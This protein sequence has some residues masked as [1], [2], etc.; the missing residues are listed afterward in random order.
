MRRRVSPAEAGR[1]LDVWLAARHPDVTR[2]QVRRWID[3]GRVRVNAAPAKAGLNLRPGDE[4]EWAPPEAAGPDEAGPPP[5]AIPLHVLHQDDDLV[6]V[7]KPPG[8]V[9]HPGAGVT[10]GT[11]VGAL[12]GRGLSLARLG[13]PHRP[14][15]VHRLDK[16]TSGLLVVARTDRAY[17]ALVR[18]IAAR[19]VRRTY[20]ALVWGLVEEEGGEIAAAIGRSRADR[21]RMTVVRRG[22]REAL[23]R[24][25]VRGRHRFLTDLDLELETGRTHQIRVHWRHRG[26]PVF[27]DPEY[28]GRPRNAGLAALDRELARRWLGLIDR[29][30]LHAARLEFDHPVTGERLVFAAPLPGDLARL[31]REVTG[32][33][34]NGAGPTPGMESV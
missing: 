21:R 28:G 29:Q 14:G 8:M 31:Y 30:A 11:L 7:D 26:H 10:R 23:T 5:E 34:E 22:G 13:G 3:A 19:Q 33:E 6:V 4:V 16:N 18:A 15:I 25:R 12:R 9:V 32:A 2:S 20:R 24:Y 27:G 1:R 17:Q